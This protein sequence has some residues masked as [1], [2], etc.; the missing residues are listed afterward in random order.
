MNPRNEALEEA[1]A[2]ADKWAEKNKTAKA[3]CS[4]QI[5][6]LKRLGDPLDMLDV[7]HQSY[8]ILESAEMEATALASEIRALKE[9]KP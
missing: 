4:H 3:K 2:L 9:I 6:R 8:S 5:A 1:A 7:A